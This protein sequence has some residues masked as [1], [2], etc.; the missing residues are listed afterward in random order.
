[1][2]HLLRRALQGESGAAATPDCVDP[3]TLAAWADGSLSGVALRR[4]EHHAADCSRCQAMLAAM[5][6]TVPETT[7]RPWWQVLT[8]RWVVPVAA[9]ATALV[10]WV[11]VD[12]QQSRPDKVA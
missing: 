5:A 6:R 9:T 12:H 4:A 8:A 7:A 10:V 2:D 3:E 1:M 11:A